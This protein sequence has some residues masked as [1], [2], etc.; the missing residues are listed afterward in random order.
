M[1]KQISINL[2]DLIDVLFHLAFLIWIISI[3]T[4][5]VFIIKLVVVV[6]LLLVMN[7]GVEFSRVYHKIKA[8]LKDD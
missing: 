3:T 5:H 2:F 6:G 7:A 1:M 4:P 8:Q